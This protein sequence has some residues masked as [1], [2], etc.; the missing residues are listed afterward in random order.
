MRNLFLRT[1]VGSA[2]LLPLAF[3]GCN[4]SGST[5]VMENAD[6]SDFEAYEK[7]IAE[8]ANVQ[9]DETPDQ[10]ATQ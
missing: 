9:N 2:L 6:E 7:M 10:D 8:D 1:F 4:D 5:N 3:A